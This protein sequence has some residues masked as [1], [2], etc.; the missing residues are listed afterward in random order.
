VPA[1]SPQVPVPS[2]VPADC[3]IGGALGFAPP[4]SGA[5]PNP[6]RFDRHRGPNSQTLGLS[7]SHPRRGERGVRFAACVR[8]ELR[9]GMR[10]LGRKGKGPQRN[11]CWRPKSSQLARSWPLSLH[12]SCIGGRPHCRAEEQSLSWR[13][14]RRNSALETSLAAP[15]SCAAGS[16]HAGSPASGAPS[17][18]KAC[19][20]LTAQVSPTQPPMVAATARNSPSSSLVAPRRFDSAA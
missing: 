14:N 20:A 8:C 12:A 9:G 17:L 19:S 2:K 15:Y 3:Q 1:R 6:R 16:Q 13:L 4:G 7:G 5:E 18:L 11:A 10:G